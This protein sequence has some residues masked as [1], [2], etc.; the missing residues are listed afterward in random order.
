MI[1]FTPLPTEEVRALQD[2]GRDAYGHLPERAISDGTGQPCRH[3]LRQVPKGETYL[4]IAHRPFPT[5]QPYA[6]TGPIFLCAKHCAPG[7]GRA[8]PAS[9]TAPAYIV[10]GYTR[11]DRILYGTG[12]VTPTNAIPERAA[13]ILENPEIAYVHVRSA[14]NNCYSVRVDRAER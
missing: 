13:E 9:L 4:I 2:G 8:I 6:E 12:R 1:T 7:G 10:K 5:T 14:A 3:C 11:D